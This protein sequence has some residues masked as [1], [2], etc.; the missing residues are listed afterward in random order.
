MTGWAVVHGR[1]DL[2]IPR[3]REL[4]AWYA[5]H[6]SFRLDLK[7]LFKTI[8]AVMDRAGINRAAGAAFPDVEDGVEAQRCSTE[9]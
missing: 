9:N 7:I 3:R 8:A 2:P 6:T 5:D 1:N 4:D